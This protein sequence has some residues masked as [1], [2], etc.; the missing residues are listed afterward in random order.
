MRTAPGPKGLPVLG[1][2]WRL[3]QD[4]LGVFTEAGHAHEVALLKLGPLPLHLLSSPELAKEVLQTRAAAFDRRT[5]SVALLMDITGESLLTANGAAWARRRRLAGPAFH[6]DR[7]AGLV[8]RF[9]SAA[10]AL[11]DGWRA[12]ASRGPLAVDAGA[13]MAGLAFRVA[14]EA[15][16]SSDVEGDVDAMESAQADVLS[17]YWK[18]MSTLSDWPQRLPNP[19]RTRYRAGLARIRAVVDRILAARTEKLGMDLLDR[20]RAEGGK[21]GLALDELR[22]EVLT[23]L[24]AGHETTAHAMA[25]ALHHLAR[26]PEAAR[27]VRREA[28]AV[29]GGRLPE[30]EDLP[31]LVQA[32]A[33]FQEA[34]RLHPTIWILERRAIQAETLGGFDIPEGGSVLVS[35]YVLHRH[36][37]YWKD[38]ERFDPARFLDEGD[39]SAYL[40]FGL[41]PHT[42]LGMGFAMAEGVTVLSVLLS[43][44]HVTAPEAV[45]PRPVAGLTLRVPGGA[46]LAFE[47]LGDA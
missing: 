1:H 31:R 30:A 41:G 15:F 36:P 42:C 19:S 34:L 18:R 47:P 37:A 16:F 38:P 44:F 32:R 27:A 25:W 40:P 12:K 24:M 6:P 21:D 20:L 3:R 26:N 14:A 17:H 5:R 13:A 39:H 4:I 45:L 23:L 22:N 2:A 11:A 43:R 28:R 8:P 10:S 9:A 29:L 7:I 35:P 33:A 46:M